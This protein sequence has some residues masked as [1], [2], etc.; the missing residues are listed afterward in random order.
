MQDPGRPDQLRQGRPRP[1]RPH[2]PVRP[3]TLE[4]PRQGLGT[5]RTDPQRPLPYGGSAPR[6]VR[7]TSLS[8]A[9]ALLLSAAAV[10]IGAGTAN[11][12]SYQYWGYYSWSNGKWAFAT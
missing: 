5:D 2:D 11:A 4:A 6:R 8:M 12:G 9:L 10:L 3:Q 1:D 7:A